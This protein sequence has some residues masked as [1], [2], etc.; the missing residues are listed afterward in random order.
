M[1]LDRPI[2]EVDIEKIR[3]NHHT[4]TRTCGITLKVCRAEDIGAA[5][6]TAMPLLV[7]ALST[8][9]S[10]PSAGEALTFI[11]EGNDF[12]FQD[13]ELPVMTSITD[14]LTGLV[15]TVSSGG[16]RSD[17]GRAAPMLT[18]IATVASD[19]TYNCTDL[20]QRVEL[21]RLIAALV[22]H[23]PHRG[24]T[25]ATAVAE[26][27]FSVNCTTV[28]SRCRELGPEM[29]V[30]AV[31]RVLPEAMYPEGFTRWEEMDAPDG[32]DELGDYE[33]K[34]FRDDE[35]CTLLQIAYDHAGFGFVSLR[36]S[37]PI[38]LFYFTASF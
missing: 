27:L 34:R 9:S 36:F 32:D 8:T 13:N 5:C 2:L 20:V 16:C 24:A 31:E 23:V 12:L 18:S 7:V 25:Y 15:T 29:F 14:H 35:V 22:E 6:L 33:F 17:R 26:V 37:T 1:S 38:L 21:A 3:R 30:A 19:A 4:R 10:R 28:E 11:V